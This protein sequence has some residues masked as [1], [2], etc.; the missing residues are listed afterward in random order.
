MP[1]RMAVIKT[2]PENTSVGED[3]EDYALLVGV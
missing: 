2:K 1:V 3:V